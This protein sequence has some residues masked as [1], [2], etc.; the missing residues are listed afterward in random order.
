[1][2]NILWMVC[3]MALLLG[4]CKSVVLVSADQINRS[5]KNDFETFAFA[6][7]EKKVKVNRVDTE[8]TRAVLEQAVVK[9]ME[10]AGYVY[11]AEDPDLLLDLRINYIRT[12]RNRSRYNNGPYNNGPYSRTFYGRYNYYDLRQERF[13]TES[14]IIASIDLLFASSIQERKLWKGVAE[15]RLIGKIDKRI[16][17]LEMAIQKL[18]V[19][20]ETGE[21][22]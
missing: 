12:D 5:N 10:D 2:R 15:T 11:S 18:I 22:K 17:R 8:K 1:M 16:E 14:N 13:V 20:F 9:E 19:G 21:E 6:E 3:G 4:A 7:I